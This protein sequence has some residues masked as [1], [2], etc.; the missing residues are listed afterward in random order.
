MNRH[1]DILS[2]FHVP[3]L[4]PDA[5]LPR[6]VV[7]ASVRLPH[8]PKLREKW[9]AWKEVYNTVCASL[10]E[11]TAQDIPPSEWDIRENTLWFIAKSYRYGDNAIEWLSLQGNRLV[12]KGANKPLVNE[13]FID[14]SPAFPV[15]AAHIER[16]FE[17]EEPP[18]DFDSILRQMQE[19]L[20]F[21]NID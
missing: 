18:E 13:F 11:K 6:K 5:P 2:G 3:E 14:V 16:A 4:P 9:G 20:G 8:L 10:A 7:T 12:Y 19:R 1:A 21:G 17:T 15:L